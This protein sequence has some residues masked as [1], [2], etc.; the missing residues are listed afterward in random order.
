MGQVSHGHTQPEGQDSLKTRDKDD[1]GQT[2][3]IESVGWLFLSLVSVVS[4][5]NNL[6]ICSLLLVRR[7]EKYMAIYSIL[8]LLGAHYHHRY[9]IFQTLHQIIQHTHTERD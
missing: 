2:M 6:S 3:N 5:E 7:M 4:C 9:S 1:L 8:H